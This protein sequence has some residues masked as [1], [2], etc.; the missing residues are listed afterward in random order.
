M[1]LFAYRLSL[2][3]EASL[4]STPR[5]SSDPVERLIAT[6]L[7]A[8]PVDE[9]ASLDMRICLGFH[10]TGAVKPRGSYRFGAG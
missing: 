7:R 6:L 3:T 8:L 5:Q 4:A 2:Q 10:G 1:L 9:Q